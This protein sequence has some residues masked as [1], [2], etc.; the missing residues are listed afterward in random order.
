MTTLPITLLLLTATNVH[1]QLITP[2]PAM[3]VTATIPTM[4]VKPL[5]KS[6]RIYIH[7]QHIANGAIK[8]YARGVNEITTHGWLNYKYRHPNTNPMWSNP[9]VSALNKY[10]NRDPQQG[11]AFFGSTTVFV[12]FTDKYHLNNTVVTFI[13]GTQ[14]TFT[15]V[16]SIDALLRKGKFKL[17]QPLIYSI[18]TM[19]AEVIAKG[20]THKYYDIY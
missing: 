17:H 18:E 19:A 9:K 20:V 7:A 5:S 10:K 8:G 12:M 6:G 11:P 14:I 16:L 4:Q 1:A 13:T 2:A 3:Q 15:A